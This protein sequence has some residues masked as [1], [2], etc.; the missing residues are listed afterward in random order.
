MI[1]AAFVAVTERINDLEKDALDEFILAEERSF[2]DDGMKI[3]GTKIVYEEGV[4]ALVDLA[5]EGEHVGM[6]RDTGMELPLASL[7]ILVALHTFDSILFT[8]VGVESSVYDAECPLA[9]NT[10][11]DECAV[12]DGLSQE[13]GCRLWVRHGGWGGLGVAGNNQAPLPGT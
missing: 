11:E 6:G 4:G 2:L 13:L 8:G 1:N 9:Q 12:I 5:M 3:A 10:H 7:I